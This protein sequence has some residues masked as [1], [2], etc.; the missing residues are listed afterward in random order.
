MNAIIVEFYGMARARAG[1]AERQLQATT[2][3]EALHA[4]I[5]ACPSLADLYTPGDT[6]ARHY[7]LSLNGERF[8]TDLDE[9]LPAA[10]RLLVL[11]ADAG[12]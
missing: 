7:L 12:G 6:L 1:C 11:S 9:P 4:I 8:V 3:R 2:V 5:A 10:A